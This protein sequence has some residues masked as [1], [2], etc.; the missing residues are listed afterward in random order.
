MSEGPAGPWPAA[1]RG[2]NLNSSSR[3][4]ARRLTRPASNIVRNTIAVRGWPEVGVR[5]VGAEEVGRAE[6]RE[7]E[8]GLG[9]GLASG[10]GKLTGGAVGSDRDRPDRAGSI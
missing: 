8:V 9:L 1:R 7:L 4:A 2:R 10:M 5:A 6:G 3:K